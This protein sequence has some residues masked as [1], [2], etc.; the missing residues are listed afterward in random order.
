MTSINPSNPFAAGGA[1]V[2]GA[3][4]QL[5][6][7]QNADG[8]PKVVE[9]VPEVVSMALQ[10]TGVPALP[11]PTLDLMSLGV[12][13]ALTLL[14]NSS[15][16]AK[17]DVI[18]KALDKGLP[19]LAETVGATM[20]ANAADDV[21]MQLG[22][23][24]IE[25]AAKNPTAVFELGAMIVK[26]VATGIATCGT[27]LPADLLKLAPSLAAA[28]AG[29]LQTAGISPGDIAAHVTTGFLQFVGVPEATAEQ[30]AK[31]TRSLV[32]VS[33]EVALALNSKGA[34]PIDPQVLTRA[35]QD[36]AEVV[37]VEPDA[38]AVVAAA[39]VHG[40]LFA[41]NIAGFLLGG[42]PLA[43]YGGVGDLAKQVVDVAN[44]AV[45]A[46]LEGEGL[47]SLPDI[48]AKLKDLEPMVQA[49]AQQVEKDLTTQDTANT[50][51]AWKAADEFIA[52]LMKDALDALSANTPP[53]MA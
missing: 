49:L 47:N 23:A 20:Q 37:G 25:W 52:Q 14:S 1:W 21:V 19:A 24:M 33:L 35:I 7:I 40:T 16:E 5:L 2:S 18:K 38:A 17:L 10:A 15:Q 6:A 48:M 27:S 45:T 50:E 11:P 28:G 3:A 51:R 53:L 12:E 42:N 41:Q 13:A 30:V 4:D 43:S 8:Q 46:F 36:I 44:T 31:V 9:M 39:A 22:G 29:V 26:T 32:D 34:D